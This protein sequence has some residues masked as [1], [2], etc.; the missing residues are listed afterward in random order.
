MSD[1]LVKQ[2]LEELQDLVRC[3]CHDA[4]KDRGLHDP[5]CCC[6]SAEAVKV[7]SDRIEALEQDLKAVLRREEDANRA[8]MKH[9]RALEQ[10]LI[11]SKNYADFSHEWRRRCEAL[12][13]Q[14]KAADALA[15]VMEEYSKYTDWFPQKAYAALAAYREADT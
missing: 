15:D 6:D 2:A 1:D 5:T 13:R 14:V 4:Y 7:V 9:L 3:Q 11:K 12:E 8:A 10:E